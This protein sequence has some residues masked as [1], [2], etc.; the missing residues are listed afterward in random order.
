V[1]RGEFITLLGGAAAW[2]LA[3]RAQQTTLPVV[4]VV[5]TSSAG[6]NWHADAR[7]PADA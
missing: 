6:V 2:P 5:S 4:G 7:L 1:N 3:A